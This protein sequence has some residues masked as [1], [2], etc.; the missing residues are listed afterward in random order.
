MSQA[1]V[2][3]VAN[4]IPILIALNPANPSTIDTQVMSTRSNLIIPFAEDTRGVA[5]LNQESQGEEE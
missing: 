1:K 2:E 4:I 3:H 5:E